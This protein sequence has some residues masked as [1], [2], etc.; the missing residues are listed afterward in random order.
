MAQNRVTDRLI[1]SIEVDLAKKVSYDGANYIWAARK[2]RKIYLLASY[3][4]FS[5]FLF[6]ISFIGLK[7]IC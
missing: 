4:P 1:I 5:K 6:V 2:D 3:S 7:L